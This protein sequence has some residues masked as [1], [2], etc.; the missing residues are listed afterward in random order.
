MYLVSYQGTY[1]DKNMG[2]NEEGGIMDESLK[3]IKF[4]KSLRYINFCPCC[5][6]DIEPKG[7]TDDIMYDF[8]CEEC[9][10]KFK[11]L[12]LRF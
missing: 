3:K 4:D 10:F 9:T 8:F 1:K 12:H 7:L 11:I 5:G 6:A 2:N